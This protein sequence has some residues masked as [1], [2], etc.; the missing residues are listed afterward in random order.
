MLLDATTGEIENADKIEISGVSEAFSIYTVS[1][2]KIYQAVKTPGVISV[3]CDR[4]PK[5]LLIVKGNSGWVKKVE[6]Y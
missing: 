4:L 1:G 6:N 3:S 5:G 2:V